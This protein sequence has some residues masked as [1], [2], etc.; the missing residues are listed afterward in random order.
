MEHQIEID[1]NRCL[2]VHSLLQLVDVSLQTILYD[3]RMINEPYSSLSKNDSPK[4]R[5]FFD[6]YGKV[7]MHK[8]L[9]ILDYQ[10]LGHRN[11]QICIPII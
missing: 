2:C 11:S 5:Q 7:S 6:L 8:C 4:S 10:I 3:H 9:L 1:L